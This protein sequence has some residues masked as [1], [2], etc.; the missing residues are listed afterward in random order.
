ME[1]ET[2]YEEGLSEAQMA[3]VEKQEKLFKS[4]LLKNKSAE[5]PEQAEKIINEA[6]SSVKLFVQK[7]E[8]PI[9]EDFFNTLEVE[10]F[11]GDIAEYEYEDGEIIKENFPAS[12]NPDVDTISISKKFVKEYPTKS[13]WILT[14]EI[15]HRLQKRSVKY[16]SDGDDGILKVSQSGFKTFT[17]VEKDMFRSDYFAL[18]EYG[19]ELSTYLAL[20]ESDT[21]A[22]DDTFPDHGVASSQAYDDIPYGIGSVVVKDLSKALN[23]SEEE[24]HILVVKASISGDKSVFEPMYQLEKYDDYNVQE[25]LRLAVPNKTLPNIGP[26][27]MQISSF[28]TAPTPELREQFYDLVK[29]QLPNNTDL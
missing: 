20:K 2:I 5:F 19:T 28:F 25:L 15:F 7:Y 13:V 11:D 27:S 16:V 14:H 12:Y 1:H 24:A 22:F 18:H 4:R 17:E 23:I 9:D 10:F 8:L 26:I 3:L 29:Q 6:V 21:F